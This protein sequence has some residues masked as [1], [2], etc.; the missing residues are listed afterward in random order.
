MNELYITLNTNI[1]ET[2]ILFKRSMLVLP[3]GV[4]L[5]A[6][7]EYP[8]LST[9]YKYEIDIMKLK[10]LP[11]VLQF[12]FNK[13][14]FTNNIE[15]WKKVGGDTYVKLTEEDIQHNILITLKFLFLS[16][17]TTSLMK[18]GLQNIKVSTA[19]FLSSPFV[20]FSLPLKLST[21]HAPFTL[22]TAVWLNDIINNKP[23]MTVVKLVHD[24]IVEYEPKEFTKAE[25]ELLAFLNETNRE[26][27]ATLELLDQNTNAIKNIINN[28]EEYTNKIK[29]KNTEIFGLLSLLYKPNLEFT[30]TLYGS[31]RHEIRADTERFILRQIYNT[32]I[33]LSICRLL[34]QRYNDEAY[35]DIQF[36]MRYDFNQKCVPLPNTCSNIAPITFKSSNDNKTFIQETYANIKKEIDR[37]RK[38][39]IDRLIAAFNDFENT[40]KNYSSRD[41]FQPLI[42]I[43][44]LIQQVKIERELTEKTMLKAKYNPAAASS[45]GS[46]AYNLFVENVKKV[47]PELKTSNQ[48]LQT[49]INKYINN[50]DLDNEFCNFVFYIYIVKKYIDDNGQLEHKLTT[51]V[52]VFNKPEE[53]HN[54]DKLLNAGYLY[55][56]ADKQIK[57][58]VLLDVL[59]GLRKTGCDI[60][61][62]KVGFLLEDLTEDD[63]PFDYSNRLSPMIPETAAAPAAA[64]PEPAAAAA[65]AKGGATRK[66]RRRRR[67]R[68]QKTKKPCIYKNTHVQLL[69]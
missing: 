1:N 35:G 55:S 21:P 23:F 66:W 4:Q 42:K 57:I 3:P 64:A 7:T 52:F 18:E 62:E 20:D 44:K 61:N 38:Y 19:S 63:K 32:F 25:N 68:A 48:A 5:T 17:A 12:L 28:N 36:N 30:E 41:P 2:P 60:Q 26:N 34:L 29:E 49:L 46:E 16:T 24:F 22:I 58:T 8:L 33:E 39:V 65:P 27:R 47:V 51:G 14:K 31:L 9:Q 40:I 56:A 43:N 15:K 45:G 6:D 11:D 54:L 50:I 67:R 13:K 10:T 69:G 59:W 37:P 53:N